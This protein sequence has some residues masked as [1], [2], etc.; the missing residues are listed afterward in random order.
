MYHVSLAR[1]VFMFLSLSSLLFVVVL[2]H[3]Q[4]TPINGLLCTAGAYPSFHRSHPWL[5]FVSVL[6]SVRTYIPNPQ[7]PHV[8]LVHS[9]SVS[10]LPL[11]LLPMVSPCVLDPRT[12][13]TMNIS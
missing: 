10:F 12:G 7:I 13:H 3:F 11:H 8:Y 2:F 1:L 6:F 9:L 4:E 5:S